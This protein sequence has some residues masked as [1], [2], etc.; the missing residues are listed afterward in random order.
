[1]NTG[2]QCRAD[3]R[4]PVPAPAKTG[5]CHCHAKQATKAGR[6]IGKPG[7]AGQARKVLSRSPEKELE[8]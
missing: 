8:P 1:M 6:A 4:C 7:R 5:I 2:I 3:P